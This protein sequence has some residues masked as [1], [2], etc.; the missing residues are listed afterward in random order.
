M[1]QFEVKMTYDNKLM[2]DFYK[3]HYNKISNIMFCVSALMLIA[4]IIVLFFN[5]LS[6]VVLCVVSILSVFIPYSVTMSSLNENKRMLNA[7]DNFTFSKDGVYIHSE[8]LGDIIFDE[9]VDY[10]FFSRVVDNKD[11]LYLYMTKNSAL[12]ILKSKVTRKEADFIKDAVLKAQKS[13]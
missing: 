7:E 8:I 2:K 13:K 6:G 9:K 5:I 4:G 3:Y 10:S 1:N 11:Y 12:I